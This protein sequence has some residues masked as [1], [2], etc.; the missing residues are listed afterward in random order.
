MNA[1]IFLIA[2]MCN[3]IEVD[4]ALLAA[5]AEPNRL[6]IIEL[7]HAAPRPVGEIAA[8]LALRQPQVTKHLQ[9]LERAGVVR[10]YPLGRRRVYALHRTPLAAIGQWAATLATAALPSEE[11][12]PH[13]QQAITDEERRLRSGRG[14]RAVRLRRTVPGSL[15]AV[16]AAWTDPVRVRRW[17]APLHFTVAD[18]VVEAVPGG[19][20][21]IVMAEG[22]GT[23]HRARGHFTDV[24]PA[25]RLAFV[26]APED[27]DGNALFTVAHIV[28]FTPAG[29][30]T[31]VALQVRATDPEPGAAPALAGLR[32]GWQQTL[33][34]L[35]AEFR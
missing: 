22:D 10:A 7:L 20:L 19:E 14:P 33:D 25:E 32:L 28:Q 11:V 17:W 27:A 15:A 4:A 16:W 3:T 9:T 12:L 6:R 23:R 29:S 24:T 8:V 30:G 31:T 35:A 34:K 1:N 13:Y 18:C 21:V 2:N 26:L 5:L